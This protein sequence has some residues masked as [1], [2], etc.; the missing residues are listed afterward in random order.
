LI[1]TNKDDDNVIDLIVT[2]KFFIF[3]F[4]HCSSYTHTCK[5]KKGKESYDK[6]M[7]NWSFI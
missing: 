6:M 7:M 3:Y 4:L 1:I 2:I 5:I